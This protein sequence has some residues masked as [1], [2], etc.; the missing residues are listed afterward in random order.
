M[1]VPTVKM[2]GNIIQIIPAPANLFA[3]YGPDME[4]KVLCLALT[5]RGDIFKMVMD[6][7][8][9]YVDEARDAESFSH[10]KWK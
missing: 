6:D 5:D 3:V 4:V 8:T 9:G 1:D 7:D 10:F 2:R